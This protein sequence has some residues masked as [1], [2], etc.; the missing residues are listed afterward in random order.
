MVRSSLL[1]VGLVLAFFA[2][3]C[4]P[5]FGDTV[6][7]TFRVAN[8]TANRL[9]QNQVI[10]AVNGTLP[11]P[12]LTVKE[13]D[14]VI[15]HV[16]NNSPYNVTIHWHG[17]FQRLT[18]WADG[19][20]FV[21]Q[22]PIRPGGNYT[23]RFNLTGQVGTLWW[24][25]HSQWLRATVHGA[26]IIR[27]RDGQNYPF[28]Q[29]DLEDTIMLGEWWN[30]DPND[31]ENAA[32][33]NGSA[34]ANADAYTINGWPGDLFNSCQSISNNTYRLN[35]SPG[36]TILLRIIN[37]ALNNQFFFKIA[38]HSFTVVAI[39]AA[40]TNPY[41]TDVIVIGPGQTTDVLLTA[42]QS[43]GLYYMAAH[44]YVSAVLP[45]LNTNITTAIL[46]YPNATQTTPILPDLPA[47]NDTPTAHTFFTNLTA[48]TTS[49][50][51]SPVPQ[52]V[53]ENMFITF[54][55]G[56]SD[57][58]ANLSCGGLFFERMA[59]SMNNLSFALPTSVSILEA[60]YR[61]ISGV[62]TT[63]FPDQ[64]PTVFDY[65][66]ISNSFDQ[67]LL[68]TNKSTSLKRLRFNSTVQIVL[69][70]TAL[71][72]VENHPM[73]LHGFN[74]YVLAQGF[75]N[76]DAANATSMFN[77]VNPQ[78]RNTLGVPVGG[79][80]VIRFRANNPGV[81]FFHCHLEVHLPWGLGMAFLVENGGTPEST[82]PPPP[83]DFPQC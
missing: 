9:C 20:E 24:H 65:T 61:N 64:P 8:L 22:C 33:A 46:V 1:A 34:P 19:P 21:T 50:F 68:M 57:C 52:T 56:L 7:T 62:Y 23:Y 54:G 40:Y 5:A 81:W 76:Y 82:L 80:A 32:L 79:W 71:I 16:I 70:N 49:P 48:L 12:A 30:A 18:Q 78:E 77:M 75:G 66:N 37:V 43:Q 29:P 42:N 74:F 27:P 55:L 67:N 69:Q 2:L 4:S 39:D 3:S 45:I 14:T 26:L 6:E 28:T 63:D 44:P 15:V 72:G 36:Q 73:H 25:A 10:S 11:G 53:D 17:V 13:G 31:V 51:W 38:N 47:F 58:G 35:V 83:A 41:Q 60:F 59:A